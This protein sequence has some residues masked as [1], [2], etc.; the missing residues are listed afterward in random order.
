MP[1]PVLGGGALPNFLW[2]AE[3]DPD[4]EFLKRYGARVEWMRRHYGEAPEAA[5]AFVRLESLT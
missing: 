2:S 5:A 3:N 1:H 4:P